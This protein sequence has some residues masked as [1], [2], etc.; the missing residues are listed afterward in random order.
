MS[1]E[2]ILRQAGLSAQA[3]I[4]SAFDLKPW[5][6]KTAVA[7][8]GEL[9]ET[10]DLDLPLDVRRD[11]CHRLRCQI[12][13]HVQQFFD[14]LHVYLSRAGRPMATLDDVEHVYTDEMLSVRGQAAL[15]HYEGRLRDVLGTR[16]YGI[17]LE[18]LTEAAVGGALHAG[19]V[20]R[21]RVWHAASV[22]DM[23]DDTE[24][25]F[26]M[27]ENILSLLEH[28]GYLEYRDDAYRFVSGLLEDW[29]RARHGR[30][31]LPIE[32]RHA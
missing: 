5:D 31:F 30:H 8:L 27:V 19:A 23:D 1:L 32:R 12:P 21:Y 7:C 29:W 24:T 26:V 10:Y 6:E 3:N 14:H 17:A 15:E 16:G 13:H 28:D 18:L 2:P 9:A 25:S 11:M 20:E 22:P 4:Y